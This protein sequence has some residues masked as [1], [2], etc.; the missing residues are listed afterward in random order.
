MCRQKNERKIGIQF[1]NALENGEPV[2]LWHVE[3]AEDE[4]GLVGGE[5]LEPFLTGGGGGDSEA[6]FLEARGHLLAL[7]WVVLDIEQ[8][9]VGHRAMGAREC[10]S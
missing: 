1:L 6:S 7:L 10:R 8:L 3:I 2:H 5:K 4:R 9:D